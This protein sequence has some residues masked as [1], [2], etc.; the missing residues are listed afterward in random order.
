MFILLMMMMMLI[1]L[2]RI[3]VKG[4]EEGGGEVRRKA[5]EGKREREKEKK[6]H[7]RKYNFVSRFEQCSVNTDV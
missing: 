6:L 5:R 7:E 2:K 4:K 1:G 3:E